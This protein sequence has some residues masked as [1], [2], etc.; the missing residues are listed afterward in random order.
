LAI[1]HQVVGLADEEMG[2]AE[3]SGGGATGPE[4]AS[5]EVV[6]ER[7]KL[8]RQLWKYW[9]QRYSLFSRFDDGVLMDEQGWY[10]V[11]PETIARCAHARPSV[12]PSVR[13]R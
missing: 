9:P 3:F 7:R 5:D 1:N 11:T 12:R 10:S 6:W 2:S 4:E 8:P 13:H